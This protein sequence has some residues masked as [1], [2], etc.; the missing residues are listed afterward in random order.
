M[1]LG[2]S[3]LA[4]G[5]LHGH[6]VGIASRIV[7]RS[8]E[9]LR[10][11]PSRS[12][13]RTEAFVSV[14]PAES[15][16]TAVSRGQG[17]TVR[18]VALAHHSHGAVSSGRRGARLEHIRAGRECARQVQGTAQHTPPRA[19]GCTPPPHRRAAPLL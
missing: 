10:N 6:D 14:V 19:A 17:S 18:S 12:A 15:R 9:S 2:I 13:L 11:D 16:Q 5:T 8:G 7:P 4:H 1:L 3:G